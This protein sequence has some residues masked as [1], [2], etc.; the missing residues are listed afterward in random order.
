MREGEALP[1]TLYAWPTDMQIDKYTVGYSSNSIMAQNQYPAAQIARYAGKQIKEISFYLR[2]EETTAYEG[3]VVVIDFDGERKA[4]VPVSA[5]DLH[6]GDITTVNLKDQELLIPADK[7]LYAGVGYSSGG[8]LDGGYYYSF[9]YFPT[10]NR[11]W[12]V[13]W[14]YFGFYSDYNLTS[15]GTRN[16]ARAVYEFY[17]GIGDY[18]APDLGYNAIADPKNGNYSAGDVFDL[19]LVE[20][21]GVRRPGTEVTWY[22]DDELVTGPSVVLT[23]GEHL[24]EAR[25][26]TT[27]GKT[28]VIELTL[29]AQ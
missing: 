22:L 29:V 27:E 14:P 21:E 5:E 20:T 2:G 10:K 1:S 3:V 28:K 6:V 23:S 13:N 25:F 9:R 24:V 12:A 18:E 19:V 11:E 17:L 16:D 4:T 8:Y 26:A 7:D 15:T